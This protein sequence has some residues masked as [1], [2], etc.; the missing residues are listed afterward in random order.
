MSEKKPKYLYHLEDLPYVPLTEKSKSRLILGE[1][2]LVSFIENPPGCVFPLHSHPSEQIYIIL[3]GEVEHICG[4]EKFLMK[5]GDVCV[6]PPNVE[7]GGTTKTGIKGI[8]VFWPPREDYVEKLKKVL[9]ER[10]EE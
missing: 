8:D 9:E 2:I 3:E 6:H 1:N 7:H 10:G 4:D 5:A